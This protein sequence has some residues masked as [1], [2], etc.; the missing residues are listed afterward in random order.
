VVGRAEDG[1]KCRLGS[2]DL[3]LEVEY[4]LVWCEPVGVS[5]WVGEMMKAAKQVSK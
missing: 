3:Y 5:S 1:R 4:T 2:V